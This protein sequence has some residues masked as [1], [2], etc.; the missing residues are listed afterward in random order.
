MKPYWAIRQLVKSLQSLN[1]SLLA[2]SPF[3]PFSFGNSC[4][5]GGV[6]TLPAEFC[7]LAES[8]VWAGSL[9]VCVCVCE[10]G[11]YVHKSVWALIP[12]PS[13]ILMSC[14]IFVKTVCEERMPF[15]VFCAYCVCTSA[16]W[17]GEIKRWKRLNVSH[18]FKRIPRGP[19][20]S[21]FFSSFFFIF[22]VLLTSLCA[23][24]SRAFYHR[25]TA[26]TCCCFRWRGRAATTPL[27]LTST[28]TTSFPAS[29]RSARTRDASSRR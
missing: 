28:S 7:T 9:T 22:K 10:G 19:W 17:K 27:C 23:G 24:K 25:W 13:F 1:L 18:L 11:W 15:S 2:L 26:G 20:I 4:A 5:R 12:S 8:P 21:F 16:A 14:L 6:L 29:H 3:S